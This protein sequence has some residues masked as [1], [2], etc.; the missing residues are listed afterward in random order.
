MLLAATYTAQNG[1]RTERA[2]DEMVWDHILTF[3]P[4]V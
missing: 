2:G 3:L 4:S 1:L